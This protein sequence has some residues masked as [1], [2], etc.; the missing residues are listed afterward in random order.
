MTMIKDV[1]EYIVQ[2]CDQFVTTLISA[3]RPEVCS[4]FHCRGMPTIARVT[5]FWSCG[6][7][8]RV[9]YCGCFPPLVEEESCD[10][11]LG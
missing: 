5:R 2:C 11:I 6:S 10:A 7:L 4:C 9:Q 1:Q 3:M 8:P